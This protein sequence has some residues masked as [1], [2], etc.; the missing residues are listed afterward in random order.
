MLNAAKGHEAFHAEPSLYIKKK[1]T[2]LPQ[3]EHGREAETAA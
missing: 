1:L 2:A 3:P